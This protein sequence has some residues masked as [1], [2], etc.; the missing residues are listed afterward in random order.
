[1]LRGCLRCAYAGLRTAVFCLHGVLIA[2]PLPKMKKYVLNVAQDNGWRKPFWDHD[3]NQNP[4]SLLVSSDIWYPLGAFDSLPTRYPGTCW[5]IVSLT[6]K[7]NTQFLSPSI[8]SKRTSDIQVPAHQAVSGQRQGTS[9]F[10]LP[11]CP[12][13]RFPKRP[14]V[15]KRSKSR[16]YIRSPHNLCLTV[17][18]ILHGDSTDTL[19]WLPFR[20][21]YLPFGKTLQVF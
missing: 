14:C 16:V 3:R 8:N 10:L 20:D 21:H 13:D 12:C 5:L 11:V 2:F 1:M 4:C 15:H 6:K 7:S 17:D 19:F 9:C 18:R